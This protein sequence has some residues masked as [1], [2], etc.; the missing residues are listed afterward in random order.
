MNPPLRLLQGAT[1]LPP[2]PARINFDR[3]AEGGYFCTA[4]HKHRDFIRA[5]EERRRAGLASRNST[6]RLDF[7]YG[8]EHQNERSRS[9]AREIAA[10]TGESLTDAVTVALRERLERL[11]TTR[12]DYV[13][14]IRRIQ[15]EYAALPVVDG[16]TA[17][18][19]I[20]YDE[21]GLPS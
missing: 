17:D 10:E 20:G 11:R 19:I 13:D 5:R 8:V 12:N 7:H 16:R 3:A 2:A 15:E 4:R 21:F 1:R 6:L 14:R 9:P 18:E